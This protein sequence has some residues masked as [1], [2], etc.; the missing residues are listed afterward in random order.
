MRQIIS[1]I[2]KFLEI[3]TIL[4]LT[5]ICLVVGLQVVGRYIFKETP[6][7]TEEVA[8]FLFVYLIAFG[9]GLAVR[10]KGYV[11]LDV[12]SNLLPP[13]AQQAM[14]LIANI[15]VIGFLAIFFI[16]SLDLVDKVQFQ[17]SPVLGLSMSFPYAALLGIG[18]SVL[19]FLLIDCWEIICKMQGKPCNLTRGGET[20]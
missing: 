17:R 7:W 16:E 14:A 8:R 3:G 12:I 11:N 9:A 15:L 4:T 1:F 5:A 10:H 6:F 18:G 2:E 19:F 13:K 20:A